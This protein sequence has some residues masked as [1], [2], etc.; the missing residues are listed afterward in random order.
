[1]F[2]NADAP[3]API[4]ILFLLLASL[5]CDIPFITAAVPTSTPHPVV[6]V[7]PTISVPTTVPSL[8][9]ARPVGTAVAQPT[10]S[11][12]PVP[13][14]GK[15]GLISGAVLAQQ[16]T[17]LSYTPIGG[18]EIFPPKTTLHV[19]VSVNNAPKSTSVKV[20]LTAIDVGSAAPPNTKAGEYSLDVAGSDNLEFSFQPVSTGFPVGTYKADILVNDILDRSLKFSVKDG[21]GV[22]PTVAIKAVGSCPPPPQGATKPSD[23]IKKVS[24]AENVK[25][26][27]LDPVNPTQ[28]FKPSSEVHAI[29]ALSGAPANT[30]IKAVWYA[31]DTGGAEACNTR[32][33]EYTIASSGDSGN[34]EFNYKP[35]SEFPSGKYRVEFYVGDTL[36]H[37]ADFSVK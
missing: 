4:A 31:L 17:P 32:I 18:G 26:S 5:A 22:I 36:S 8:G 9:S 12:Q 25:G 1:M 33:A 7:Q 2:L 21:V 19:V 30:A 6:V 23:Y 3:R 16:V 13:A 37:T 29:V 11:A 10:A 14:T 24:L 28:L 15:T 35:P 34:M 27:T 20:V